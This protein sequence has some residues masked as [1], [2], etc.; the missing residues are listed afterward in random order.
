MLTRRTFLAS[1]LAT[2]GLSLIPR[3]LKGLTAPS[4]YTPLSNYPVF[5]K[6]DWVSPL[7]EAKVYHYDPSMEPSPLPLE[8]IEGCPHVWRSRRTGRLYFS[9][10]MDVTDLSERE[11]MSV[12]SS[13]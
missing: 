12:F 9:P 1:V 8:P 2:L 11:L 13:L 6:H 10:G 4:P 5:A 3:R 7:D